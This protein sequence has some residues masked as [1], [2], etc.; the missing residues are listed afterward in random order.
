MIMWGSYYQRNTHGGAT[1]APKCRQRNSPPWNR[2][3]SAPYLKLPRTPGLTRGGINK[4]VVRTAPSPSR[5]GSVITA[6][7][8]CQVARAWHVMRR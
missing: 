6:R 7:R 3:C 2:V 1:A 5:G 4:G 8:H